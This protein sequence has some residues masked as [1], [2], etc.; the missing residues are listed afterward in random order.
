MQKSLPRT[1][2]TEVVM[3]SCLFTTTGI[4]Y[5]Q[6]KCKLYF[7]DIELANSL[8]QGTGAPLLL[9][10][11]IY[12]KVSKMSHVPDHPCVPLFL[13][14]SDSFLPIFGNADESIP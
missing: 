2:L 4:I 1:I 7:Y 3:T 6:K 13:S 5:L 14:H 12:T 11:H 8:L 9:Q 10:V